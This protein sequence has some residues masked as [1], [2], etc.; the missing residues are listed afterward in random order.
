MVAGLAAGVWM[1]VA[2]AGP[3]GAWM[4][5]AGAWM[6]V[7]GASPWR[8]WKRLATGAW[9]CRRVR[10][11]GKLAGCMSLLLAGPASCWCR[12]RCGVDG[13]GW[14]VSLAWM[15]AAGASP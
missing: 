7:D 8:G 14:C 11:L 10:R 5:A 13:S 4:V 6:V 2:A 3:A 12:R 15:V 9:T 1:V